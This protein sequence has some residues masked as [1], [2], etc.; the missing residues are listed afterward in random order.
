MENNQFISFKNA[1]IFYRVTGKGK[2][3]ALIHGFG[4]D[5]N[6]WNDTVETLKSNFRV[7]VPDIPGSGKSTILKEENT[8]ISI[9]DYAE[10]IINVLQNESID[11]CSV[12]GH[13]MGG[14]IALAIAEKY[15]E[16]LNG[17]GLFHSTAFQDNEERK[18]SRLK[19]IEFLQ[20][21]DA[22][23]F[24]KTSIAG[25]FAEKFKQEH[26]DIVEKLIDGGRSFS[27]EILIQYQTAMMSRP[28]R[29]SVLQKTK[30]PV[31]FIIG[32]KDQSI[33]LQQSLTQ[34]HIPSLSSVYILPN[35]G[36]MGMLEERELSTDAIISY[37]NNI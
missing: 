27:S 28:E 30:L 19:S 9:N 32:E 10:V 26:A 31:L 8:Q 33:P 14:Y 35:A 2:T 25:L 34:C 1:K 17:F 37:L 36:H 22:I 29:T 7:I 11:N 15:N 24:L 4:E 23:S 12:I 20:T 21:H 13:S 16:V 5:G 18:Q 3:V 6:I